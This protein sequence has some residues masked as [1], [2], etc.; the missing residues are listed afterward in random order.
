MAPLYFVAAVL[1]FLVSLVVNGARWRAILSGLGQRVPLSETVLINWCSIFMGN[2]TPGRVGG[3][4]TRVLLLQKR[5]TIDVALGGVSQGYDRLTDLLPL[6]TMI[7]LTLPTV[8]M[9][10]GQWL[11]GSA[12]L[13]FGVG[14]IIVLAIVCWL[15]LRAKGTMAWLLRWQ[16]HFARF[17]IDKPQ[18]VLAVVISFLMWVLDLLRLILVARAVGVMIAPQQALTLCVVALLGGF[19]PT[20]GGLGVV[21]GGL[22]AALV[23]FGVSVDKALAIA[24]LERSISLGLGT[25]GGGVTMVFFGGRT[26]WQRL[27]HPTVP[28]LTEESASAIGSS[29]EREESP[30]PADRP[31]GQSSDESRALKQ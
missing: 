20:A 30:T 8:K 7:I 9:V 3:E 23:L 11:P 15:A 14:G 25:I 4:L 28:V 26:L 17:R 1:C 12:T 31:A 19:A 10:L 29:Q 16:E 2:V 5:R 24:L 21:E 18:F 6:I 27:R 22:T 13:A